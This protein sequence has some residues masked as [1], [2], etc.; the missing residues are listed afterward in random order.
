MI[1]SDPPQPNFNWP[2][3]WWMWLMDFWLWVRSKQPKPDMTDFEVSEDVNGIRFSLRANAASR[4]L[5]FLHHFK[6]FDA[7]TSTVTKLKVTKHSSLMT[8]INFQ[9]VLL[10]TDLETPLKVEDGSYIVLTVNA[11]GTTAKVESLKTWPQF[12]NVIEWV[13]ESAANLVP[14]NTRV[15]IAQCVKSPIKGDIP[16]LT[17]SAGTTKLDVVQLVTQP[18]K[19]E[20]RCERGATVLYPQP[21]FGGEISD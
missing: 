21:W 8:S 17:I 2:S 1:P 11:A 14:K 20:I 18:M 19:L 3:K 12:P 9:D 16:V 13:D 4:A 7:S 5:S 15:A 6:V 10:I